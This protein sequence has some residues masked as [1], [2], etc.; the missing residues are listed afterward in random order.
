MLKKLRIRFILIGTAAFAVVAVLL[1]FSINLVNYVR[2]TAQHDEV[3]QGIHEYNRTSS[4][5]EEMP[6]ITEMSWNGRPDGEFTLRFF[7]IRCNKDGELLIFDD[8]YI[9][10]IDEDT[11]EAYTRAVLDRHQSS[12]YYLDYR[13]LVTEDVEEVEIIFL[14]VADANS[15]RH[16]L[17]IISCSIGAVG[18]LLVFLLITAFSGYAIR[19]YVKNL[20]QQKQF[21][22]DAGHELKTPVT[23]IATSADIL[24]MDLEDNEW[25]GDIQKQ[26]SHLARL[27]S[28]LVLLSRLDEEKPFPDA[29]YFS[30]SEAVWEASE[31]YRALAAAAGKHYTH[32]IAE[33][34]TYRGDKA[35][36]QQML[37]VL[38]DNALRYSEE[39]GL[40]R[41]SLSTR[42]GRPLIEVFN[43]CEP[44][45]NVDPK[46]FFD[47]FYRP[48]ASRSKYTGGSGIGLSIARAI[49]ER[50]GGSIS[51]TAESKTSI[52]FSVLL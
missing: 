10:S 12:G 4:G 50:Q 7:S 15:F 16:L 32:E 5:K 47:R 20:E 43:T 27:I 51:V 29:E 44:L 39:G 19:P 48:D 49:A 25:V 33:Q 9:S 52:R 31:H 38:L 17:L 24:A 34:V 11:A 18:L 2:T 3:L 42:H 45:P 1:I 46:R 30:L 22:T 37:S 35:S 23:S 8:A 14:N 13:Y 26:S 40:I 36:V 6:P 21:I 41:L 28:N